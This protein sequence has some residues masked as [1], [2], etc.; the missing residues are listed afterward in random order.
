M[1]KGNIER[2]ERLTK[3]E[4]GKRAYRLYLMMRAETSYSEAWIDED[5]SAVGKYF[6]EDADAVADDLE[7]LAACGLLQHDP[8]YGY[9]IGGEPH[10]V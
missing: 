3:T 2:V 10:A 9:L 6:G 8:G 7:R 1:N 4:E 5:A